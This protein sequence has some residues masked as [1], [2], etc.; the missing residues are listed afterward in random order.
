MFFFKNQKQI[1]KCS[2]L[3]TNFLEK[4]PVRRINCSL[5][6][7][8]PIFSVQ[9]LY[10]NT[11]FILFYFRVV[12]RLSFRQLSKG[13]GLFN[14]TQYLESNEC[15]LSFCH[16]R[17]PNKGQSLSQ[18]WLWDQP[19]RCSFLQTSSAPGFL[20]GVYCALM[21]R[22]TRV[23]RPISPTMIQISTISA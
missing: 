12:M 13:K 5:S 1:G 11:Q 15:Q 8:S 10:R 21:Q 19:A 4:A 14:P 23:L 18:P 9:K 22:F 3:K 7:T 20:A 16:G 2:F 6:C 17:K